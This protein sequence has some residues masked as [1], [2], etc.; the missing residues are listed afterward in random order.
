MK[1]HKIK[2]RIKR[3]VT[4][5]TNLIHDQLIIT[6]T[7]SVIPEQFSFSRTAVIWRYNECETIFPATTTT[8]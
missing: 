8:N 1:L 5:K 7:D 3:K 6:E 2:Q 4:L